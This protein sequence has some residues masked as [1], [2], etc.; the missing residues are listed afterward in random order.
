MPALRLRLVTVGALV[1]PP[2]RIP[3]VEEIRQAP[4]NGLVAASC[5]AGG[6]G[7]S[8]GYRWAGYEV[9]WANEWLAAARETYAANWPSTVLD[10]RDIREVEPEDV[11]GAC[12]VT[13]GELDLLDASPPCEPFSMAGRRH[14]SWGDG[15]DDLYFEFVRLVRGVRPRAFAAENVPGLM[16]G[17]ARG[18]YNEV[19]RELAAC[20]YRVRAAVLDAQWLGVPQRRRRLWIV[21]LRDDL[22][23]DPPLPRPLPWRYTLADALPH[24]AGAPVGGASGPDG[25]RASRVVGVGGRARGRRP[26]LDNPAPAVMAHGLGGSAPHQ[27]VVAYHGR[28]RGRGGF[29]QGGTALDEPAE[30]VTAEGYGG[31][32]DGEAL[33]LDGRVTHDPETGYRVTLNGHV[34]GGIRQAV[35]NDAFEPRSG[36]SAGGGPHPTVMAEGSRTSGLIEEAG[37]RRKFTLG[38]LRALCG[39]PPDYA[40]TGSYA[41]RWERLGDAVPPPMARAVGEC[42]AP[43]LLADNTGN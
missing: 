24:L 33:V 29:M 34:K 31:V 14:R 21:G 20:G 37:G 23:A 15:R 4:P 5:F 2:Y 38:E 25:Q 10:P 17:K 6:G 28:N 35:G 27:T 12:G 9:R 8:T 42:L 18:Y 36:A 3:A 16:A 22:D 41:H 39:F 19:R 32:A 11:L 13:S 30:T 40:L 1:R 26:A 7:S 43:L